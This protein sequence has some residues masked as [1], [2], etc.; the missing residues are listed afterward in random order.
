MYDTTSDKPDLLEH[1]Q[2]ASNSSDLTVEADRRGAG[3]VLIASGWSPSRVGAA[4]IRLRSEWDKA[5]KPRRL[6]EAQ[7]AALAQRMP[8]PRGKPDIPRARVEANLWYVRELRLLATGLQSRQVAIG[9]VTAWAVLKAIPEA[10]VGPALLHWLSPNC[11]RCD[12]HGRRKV[13]DQPALSAKV[14]YHCNGTGNTPQGQDA[15]RIQVWLDECVSKWR[16]STRKA[17]HYR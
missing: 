7:V 8:N 2:T 11:P 3:D 4:L 10:A 13:P 6:S 12:G 16:Q 15:R 5:A 9:H 17:L 1:Y 14:C